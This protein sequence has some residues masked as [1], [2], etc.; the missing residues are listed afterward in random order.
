MSVPS[1]TAGAEGLRYTD[2]LVALCV[3]CHDTG[4]HPTQDHLVPMSGT[5]LANLREFEE[6]RMVRLPLEEDN[7]VTCVTCHNPHERGLL[8]GPAGVGADEEM[9]L[10]LTTMNEQCT[11]CHGRH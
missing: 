9:R 10:R 3:S 4:P 11:P 7:R 1:V 5:K 8:K 6:R 2:T